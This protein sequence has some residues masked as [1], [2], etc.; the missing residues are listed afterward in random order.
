MMR[1]IAKHCAP[2]L[3][4]HACFHEVPID[5][6]AVDSIAPEALSRQLESL[7]KAFRFVPIDELMESRSLSGLASVTFDDGYKGVIDS[8]LP[9]FEALDIPFTVFVN[10]RPLEGQLFW[11]HKV[12]EIMSLGLAGECQASM[13]GMHWE[14]GLGFYGSLKHPR[15]NS[16]LVEEQIDEFLCRRNIRLSSSNH[17]FDARQYYRPHRLI[18]FGNHSH[19]HYVLSS[20]SR[21]EQCEEISRTSSILQTIP[22]IQLSKVFALPFGQTQHANAETLSALRENGYRTLLM[23]RG[24]TNR[25]SFSSQSEVTVIERFS[26]TQEISVEKQLLKEFVKTAIMRADGIA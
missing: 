21:Q 15:N 13:S 9:I 4:Y 10:T 12:V 7:K 1:M 19:S 24:R 25:G 23:N 22:G 20:L 16:R 6:A 18:W 2:V 14:P 3:N 8:A 11:R 17:L 5:V 26:P